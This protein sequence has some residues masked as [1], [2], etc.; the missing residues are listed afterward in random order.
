MTAHEAADAMRAALVEIGWTCGP[1]ED[2]GAEVRF[3]VHAGYVRDR[4]TVRAVKPHRR[5]FN[6]CGEMM[7]TYL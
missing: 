5:T 2:V 1:L 4:R 3:T 6:E 7:V